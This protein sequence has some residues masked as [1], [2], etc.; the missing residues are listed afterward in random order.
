MVVPNG[1]DFDRFAGIERA[2]RVPGARFTI[3]GVGRQVSRKGFGWFVSEVMPRL[4]DEVSLVLVGDG[5]EREAIE[6][7]VVEKGLEDRVKLRG[8][9]PEAELLRELASADLLVMPNLP[10]PG[11]MEGFG[12]VAV[13]AAMRGALVLAAD[14]EGLRD[15][16]VS[17][18]TGMLIPPHDAAAWEQA[19]SARI[20]DRD[21]T[22][23]VAQDYALECRRR[24]S[25]ER[26]GRELC[27]V[28]GLER[29]P[30]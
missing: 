1:V 20:A 22:R 17:G 5:P 9:V 25:R 12:L 7:L 29:T 2:A 16:V 23:A 28:L 6:H 10:V 13:E 3:L 24:Y 27:D 8:F 4:P 30:G 21:G 11:D 15:A 18:E 26:M 19:L 14:L